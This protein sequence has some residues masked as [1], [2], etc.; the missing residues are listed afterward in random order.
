MAE[1]GAQLEVSPPE[2]WD[3]FANNLGSDL[4]PLLALFGEQVT[5]QYL[6]ESLS[7]LDCALFAIAPLGIITAMVA[8]IRVAGEPWLRSMI[9]R[10]KESRGDVEADLM[11]STSSDVCELWNGD[12][13][14]RVLGCPILLHLIH[15]DP[16]N[17]TQGQGG[18]TIPTNDEKVE[19]ATEDN[20]GIY[21]FQEAIMLGLYTTKESANK[22]GEEPSRIDNPTDTEA[23][24]DIEELRSR[25]NPPNL[26]LNVSVKPL[27]PRILIFLAIIGF[28]LQA[29]VLIWAVFSQY[30]L[31]LQKNDA[32]PASYG[33]PIFAAG[34]V[35]LALGM[36]GCAWA[37]ESSTSEA[38]WVPTAEHGSKSVL[39]LQQGGQ[40]VGDQRFESWSR[41]SVFPDN[42]IT[43]SHK[44]TKTL[45]SSD[46]STSSPSKP[47]TRTALVNTAITL[48][49]TGFVLQFFGLRVLHSSVTLAQ[50]GAILIMTLIRCFGHIQRENRNDITDPEQVEGHELDWL[51]KDLKACETWE[52]I[53]GPTD[54]GSST[55]QQSTSNAT[56]VSS[57]AAVEVMKIRAR[58]ARLSKDWELE[59][60]TTV[61][62]L[63]NA[64]E[65]TMKDVFTN[66][67]LSTKFKN[68][69]EFEWVIW[70]KTEFQ[71]QHTDPAQSKISEIKLTMKR[72]KDDNSNWRPWKIDTSELE[73]VLCL[74]VSS[75][76][77][78]NKTR[79]KQV[80]RRLKHIRLLGLAT[81]GVKVDYKLWIHRGTTATQTVLNREEARYFGR[82]TGPDRDNNP[83]VS[84]N[85]PN[86]TPSV[87]YL[88][89]DAGG[90]LEMICAQELY[91]S[92]LFQLLS[93]V[94]IVGG[95]TTR[96]TDDSTTLV[97]DT[98][99]ND[100]WSQFRLSNSNLA[101]IARVYYECGLGTVESAYLCIVPAFRSANKL[102]SP[103]AA[104]YEAMK[105]CTKLAKNEEWGKV[106]EIDSWLYTN[107]RK[108]HASRA[109]VIAITTEISS[110]L[111]RASEK[112]VADF[113][114]ATGDP[115][116]T[117]RVWNSVYS[118]CQTIT[119]V[120]EDLAI[121]LVNL[122]KICRKIK[123]QISGTD[124]DAVF[125]LTFQVAN[126]LDVKNQTTTEIIRNL[127]HLRLPYMSVDEIENYLSDPKSLKAAAEAD[128]SGIDNDIRVPI[129]LRLARGYRT[130]LQMV[131]E[132]GHQATVKSLLGAGAGVNEAGAEDEG[133]TAL[134]AAAGGGHKEIVE[135]LLA[136]DADVNIPA[137]NGGRT[138]LQ[139]A[140][141][142]G[143]KDVVQILLD[144]GAD[145][146]APPSFLGWTALQAAAKGGHL[147][148][149]KLLLDLKADVNAPQAGWGGQ[150][151]VGAAAEGGHTEMISL[152]LDAKADLGLP[153]NGP[154]PLQ[155]AAQG[156]YIKMVKL[157]LGAGADSN[158][159]SS[160]QDMNA[161]QAAANGGHKEIVQILVDAGADVNTEAEHPGKT[162]L[163][164]AAGNNHID[165][166]EILLAA[167]ADVNLLKGYRGRS[168]LEAAAGGGHKEITQTLLNAG[169][170]VDAE[171]R[172]DGNT[173]LKAAAGAGHKE[174]VEMLLAA[175][176]DV[177]IPANGG[178]R[179]A[180][181][182]AAEG[183]HNE[184]VEMLLTAKPDLNALS[185]FG[186]ETALQ[187]AALG[188]HKEV[189]EL[190]VK[191]R[192]D[193]NLVTQNGQRNALQLAAEGGHIGIVK[194]LLDVRADLNA[195]SADKAKTPLQAA[196]EGGHDEVVELLLEVGA[197]VKGECMGRRSL[198]AAATGGHEEV[199][200]LL[201]KAKADVNALSYYDGLERTAL[202]AAAGGGHTEVVQL[203]LQAKANVHAA[204]GHRGHSALEAAADLGQKDAPGG[205]MGAL[206][207]IQAAAGSGNKDIVVLLLAA[208]PDISAPAT[209]YWGRTALQAAAEGGHKDMVEFLLASNVDVNAIAADHTGRTALQA[210]SEKGHMGV[211]KLLLAA[212]ADI[213]A[214]ASPRLGRTALQAAAQGG[215]KEVVELLLAAG[216][217][218]NAR[219][220]GQAGYT[221]LQAA[222]HKG[223]KAIVKLLLAAKADINARPSRKFGRTALQAAAGEGH[224]E[225]V[226]LLLDAG[227]NVNAPAAKIWGRTALQ[228]AEDGRHFGIVNILQKA[229][230]TASVSHLSSQ[231][232]ST[233]Q[234]C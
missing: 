95:I 141:G 199:V 12:G 217:D 20:A 151:A 176:A 63:R 145:C 106:V 79:A 133:R 76:T 231:I 186:N 114:S 55:L 93:K 158:A 23:Y 27:D 168:A 221:A 206:T 184:V 174:V 36:F 51:A 175:G 211:V 35:V 216:A 52:V 47:N 86:Q 190:L 64:I 150:T 167:K 85:N 134:Q 201:L 171:A 72:E 222:S 71:D 192:V 112:L 205:G 115:D 179:T 137:N 67:K 83:K 37:V 233:S 91:T 127:Y 92:F 214:P 122:Y 6:S 198:E 81:E 97:S 163:E 60:R 123:P 181:Q 109:K 197:D 38:I 182:A 223:N 194:L 48:A 44:S 58:L 9:G 162:A 22:P 142:S 207:A 61:E 208:N 46:Q 56:N 113:E 169:A 170:S 159:R 103:H 119:E 66:M 94:E 75:L 178:G 98:S 59:I 218:V 33:F 232:E 135:I 17:N 153:F 130:P 188:G 43:T 90:K 88:C 34:T 131:A 210:A 100:S 118:L 77:N 4:A 70:V 146:N 40:I 73:A 225:L 213:N 5:K 204:A 99:S 54:H 78:V 84:S 187:A 82:V 189:V 7:W 74:W 195:I 116:D 18:A 215:Q 14:V 226:N 212:K 80:L 101:S 161:L 144:A 25:Q 203:L 10:A 160:H 219:A 191:A 49:F 32:P 132:I 117:L 126:E 108:T 156:G 104:Y 39:W 124:Q 30:S 89:V 62:I 2:G 180:L 26:A 228:A 177:N 139:A 220:V 11:S 155:F 149:A 65:M 19:P 57:A 196:A 148:I 200:K 230:D 68:V 45:E 42:T 229:L 16:L 172:S 227:A 50:L 13:I 154:G 128:V 1:S 120:S 105:A 69:P 136:A 102:P 111:R 140:A 183:G 224:M 110:R 202:Q 107:S 21:T 3:N 28:L 234:M 165:V 143:H 41:R 125:R 193:V 138:A 53:T 29:S 8:A 185:V 24:S 209:E 87:E 157:L 173:A 31:K 121:A 96:R 166:V 129:D 147:E 164:A 15:V 152:L